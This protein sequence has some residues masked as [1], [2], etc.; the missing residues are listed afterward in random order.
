M[1]SFINLCRNIIFFKSCDITL[2]DIGH[3]RLKVMLP[4]KA[5]NGFLF[6]VNYYVNDVL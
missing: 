1:Q 2:T 4:L 3:L 5:C 6:K